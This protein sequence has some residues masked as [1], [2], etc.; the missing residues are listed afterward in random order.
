MNQAEGNLKKNALEW[1]VFA[2]SGLLIA[3]VTAALVWYGIHLEEG[4]AEIGVSL[5]EPT[6]SG[7]RLVVPVTVRNTG[8]SVASGVQVSVVAV[9]GGSEQEAEF[10]VDFIP[11]GGTRKGSVSFP[12]TEIPEELRWEVTGYAER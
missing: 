1:V 10:S 11:R 5:S 8:L 4:P 2:T 12:G 9:R 7:G 3:A 6:V